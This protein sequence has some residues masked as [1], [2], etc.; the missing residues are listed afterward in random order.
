[1][2]ENGQPQMTPME[3]YSGLLLNWTCIFGVILRVVIGFI[4]V[5]VL[6][7]LFGLSH[8]G[9]PDYAILMVAPLFVLGYCMSRFA[10]SNLV[11][12]KKGP[13]I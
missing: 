5:F 9:Y 13:P 1:M 6:T 7:D 2:T 11:R 8:W 4:G 12:Q 10:R 3:R